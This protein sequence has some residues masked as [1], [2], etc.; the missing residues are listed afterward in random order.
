ML[1]LALVVTLFA[2]A[3]FTRR[4]MRMVIN[5][6]TM[7]VLNLCL[8]HCIPVIAGVTA[9]HAKHLGTRNDQNGQRGKDAFAER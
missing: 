5:H 8:H 7:A 1:F 4:F 6:H 2:G 3:F 9:L